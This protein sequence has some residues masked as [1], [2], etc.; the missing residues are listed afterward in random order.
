MF[1]PIFMLILDFSFIFFIIITLDDFPKIYGKKYDGLREELSSSEE[2]LYILNLLC[3]DDRC[4][5]AS[6][7][8]LYYLY[9]SQKESFFNRIPIS[10]DDIVTFEIVY[11]SLATKNASLEF[12][13]RNLIISEI[14]RKYL[15]NNKIR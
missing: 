15:L 6:Q 1:F 9:G 3:S 12:D 8:L 14:D 2:G 13:F 5:I 11:N 4:I 7:I 10:R